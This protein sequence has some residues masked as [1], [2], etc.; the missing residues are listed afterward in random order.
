MVRELDT[1]NLLRT[2]RGIDWKNSIGRTC[3]FT[4]DDICSTITILDYKK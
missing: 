3:N 2:N 4:Y 1:S